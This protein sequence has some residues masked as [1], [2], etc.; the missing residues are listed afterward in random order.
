[1]EFNEEKVS[2]R[3]TISSASRNVDE[4]KYSYCKL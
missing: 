3:L 4:T 1:M 2:F